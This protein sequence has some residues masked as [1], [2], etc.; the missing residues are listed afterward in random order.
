MLG[1]VGVIVAAIIIR[2]TGWAWVDSL[3]AVGIGLWILP[4]TWIVL[5]ESLNILL[6]G[7]PAGIDVSEVSRAITALPGIKGMHDSHS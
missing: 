2:A 5:K 1:S 6:E 4:R 7:T 3:V